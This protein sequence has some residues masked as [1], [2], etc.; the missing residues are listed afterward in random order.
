M[1]ISAFSYHWNEE[2]KPKTPRLPKRWDM[3]PG[4]HGV[5]FA[6]LRDCSDRSNDT[7]YRII[8]LRYNNIH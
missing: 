4:R 6:L 2:K 1:L 3:N 7:L 8:I 5:L